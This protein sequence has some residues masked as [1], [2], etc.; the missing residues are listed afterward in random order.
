MNLKRRSVLKGGAATLGALA[1]PGLA[2][3]AF[4]QDDVIQ[5]ANI[6]D[7]S[8]GF[9]IYGQ[10]QL[11]CFQLA[12]EEINKSGGLL[13]KQ[14]ELNSFDPQ[15]DIQL[16]TQYA[17][18]VA[19]RIQPPVVFAGI[20]SASREAIRP[21]FNRFNTLYFY[22]SLYEGGVCDRNHFCT[23]T[24]PAQT[25]EKLVPFVMNKF[26]GK[27]VYV[28]AAD[29]NYGWISARWVKHYV[30][31]NGGEVIAD[32]YF[33]LEVT[34]FGPAI[35][36]I[37][38]A[39]PDLIYS[40]LVGGNHMSFFRQWAAAGLAGSIP[41]FSTDF[42]VGNEHIVLSKE[43]SDGMHAAY[44]YVHELDT[45]ANK[46][47]LGRMQDKFGDDAPYLNELSIAAY[48]AVYHW[49]EAVKRAGTLERMPVIEALEDGTPFDG[50]GGLSTIDPQTHHRICDV[51]IAEVKDNAFQV[52]ETHAQLAPTDTQAVCNLIENP[53]ENQY[54]TIE[55]PDE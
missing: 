8:G 50:P 47:F 11:A 54:F 31:A 12:V 4:A 53:N 51:H 15:S 2:T 34:E 10:A 29:Y 23:G 26:A 48:Y 3:K 35:K 38:A 28:I 25:I 41:M 20:S 13:G 30:E 16:Y 52:L 5:I 33:P 43:E 36:N 1:T 18:E 21:I 22:P 37:Q 42:G 17:T 6:S 27:K 40:L 7:L 14:L 46:A 44:S 9:D 45:P 32:E 39:K 55:S 49:A 19:T 24:T